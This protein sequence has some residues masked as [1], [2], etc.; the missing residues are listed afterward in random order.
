M[1]GREREDN[2]RLWTGRRQQVLVVVWWLG[3]LDENEERGS[4]VKYSRPRERGRK[5][6]AA[7][8]PRARELRTEARCCLW[9]EVAAP[10]FSGTTAPFSLVRSS[11]CLSLS[12]CAGASGGALLRAGCLLEHLAKTARNIAR[13]GDCDGLG[14]GGTVACSGAWNERNDE[15]HSGYLVLIRPSCWLW[16]WRSTSSSMARRNG[17][18]SLNGSRIERMSA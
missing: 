14:C 8:R 3:G 12:L 10:A 11:L 18:R 9:A 4:G 5:W 16:W 13:H 17:F 2:K 1:V 7:S 6:W 15:N